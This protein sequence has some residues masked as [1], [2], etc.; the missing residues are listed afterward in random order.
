MIVT[1]DARQAEALIA[2]GDLDVLDVRE[3]NEWAD[4]YIP[5]AR[6]VPLAAL[7]A[8]PRGVVRGPRALFL[9]ARGGRSETAAKAAQAAGVGEVYSLDGGIFAWMA[10]GLPIARPQP[11]ESS[12]ASASPG[13][14]PA[15]APEA[16][17][18]AL[19]AVIGAN[20][21]A[22]RT[23]RGLSLDQLAK[24]TGLSRTTLGQIELG[25]AAPSVG[26]IW[27]IARAFDVPFAT[28]LATEARVA[29]TVLRAAT[30][31]RLVS[32]DG[33]FSSRALYTPGAD[34]GVEF[35]E[36]Y[37]APH[38]REDAAP[39]PAGTREHLVVV[40]GALDLEVGDERHPLRKGDAA[41]FAADVPHAYVNPGAE[42]CWMHLVMTYARRG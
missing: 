11:V 3:A 33:R 12:A 36:L 41:R 7:R 1:V 4:G 35:Y 18:P 8:D 9:C 23:E 26:V 13:P 42:P 17:E 10:A 29:T 37:L 6:H 25:R 28:L 19:D 5:G 32:P 31:R 34:D 15:P 21:R 22:L 38:S 40:S 16:V 39:H 14:A 24:V 30:A 2:A 27:K 20:L